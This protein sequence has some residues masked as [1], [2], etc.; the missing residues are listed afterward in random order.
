LDF[1]RLTIPISGGI[2]QRPDRQA[3]IDAI[4]VQTGGVPLPRKEYAVKF[5]LHAKWRNSKGQRTERNTTNVVGVIIDCMAE[6]FGFG[7]KG[8]GDQ[9]LDGKLTIEA[10]ESTREVAEV[11]MLALAP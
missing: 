9:L 6:A 5:V 10:I 4:K 3:I 7:K 2:H 1:F 8:R 11:E